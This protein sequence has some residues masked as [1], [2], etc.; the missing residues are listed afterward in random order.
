[1]DEV[2]KTVKLSCLVSTIKTKQNTSVSSFLDINWELIYQDELL[3]LRKKL[4][5][6]R[7]IR[8]DPSFL[9]H[10]SP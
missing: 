1:N 6:N 4:C 5:C 7:D 2:E 8:I 3:G 10:R 9:L